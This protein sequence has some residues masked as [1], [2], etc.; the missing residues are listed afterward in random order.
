MLEVF[1]PYIITIDDYEGL[2]FSY[3]EGLEYKN[4]I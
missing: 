1:V 4:I 2:E 3:I